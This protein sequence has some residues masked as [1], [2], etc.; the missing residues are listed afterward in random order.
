MAFAMSACKQKTKVDNEINNASSAF[1]QRYTTEFLTLA[2]ASSEAQWKANTGIREG[3]TTVE[4]QSEKAQTAFAVFC[5]KKITLDS[6]EYFISHKD[7]LEMMNIKQLEMI[8][9]MGGASAEIADSIVKARIKAET[10]A[11]S[12]LFGFSYKIGGKP[13][14]TNDIDNILT[15]EN[16]LQKRQT[17]WTASKEVGKILKDDLVKLRELRNRSVQPLGYSDYFA[18]KVQDYNMNTDEMM[19]L[20]ESF[21]TS[22][23][24]LYREI[25]TYMRYHLAEKYHM[26]VPDYLPAHWLPNRWG[27]D[28]SA[29]IELKGSNLDSALK[30][31]TAEQIVRKGEQFYTSLGF[32][33]LKPAFWT[34]SSL[35]P[36]PADSSVKKNN[37][38]SAWHVNLADDVRSL[39][40]VEPS[41]YWWKAAHHELG[42]VYYFN[43]YSTEAVPTLLRG[44]ANRAYH[45]AI[46]DL[47][48]LAS[49]QSPYLQSQQLIPAGITED[50]MQK[51]F[52]EALTY[53]VVLPWQAG[54][55]THFEKDLYAGNLNANKFNAHWWE[56]VKKYQGIVPPSAR[57]EEYCDASTKTHI[58]DDAAEYYDYAISSCLLMQMHRHI[59][60]D[61]LHQDPHATNYYGSKATGDFLRSIMKWGQSRDWREVLKESTGQEIN[62]DAMMEYFQPLLVW[63][64][65]QN[66]GKQH[67]LPASI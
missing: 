14:T 42:H 54:V 30:K 11:T 61:I 24:P 64:R 37:H 33:K 58:I 2:T 52:K 62:A 10:S 39:M 15:T 4:A 16:D 23:W 44:G 1:I 40:S 5:G 29:L 17:A 27:Q 47:L 28:W 18:Y 31:F 43:E 48:G 3:D 13:V 6:V 25:H 65:M 26:P 59:A 53:V 9:Y 35:Y 19:K 22:V 36:Y 55:M 20:N 49:T 8:K 34:S 51:L 38:A 7:Q 63:L 56:L 67:T 66:A 57:G 21:V 12:A 60:R 45:E 46:G 41:T 50:T 32:P